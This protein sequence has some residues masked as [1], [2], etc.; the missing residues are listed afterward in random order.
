MGG[1]NQLAT[2]ALPMLFFICCGLPKISETNSGTW[3]D[4][5]P[6]VSYFPKR[7]ANKAS[8]RSPIHG[9]LDVGKG[10]SWGTNADDQN[11]ADLDGSQCL[12]LA[13]Q[14]QVASVCLLPPKIPDRAQ[15]KCPQ[16]N[17][18]AERKRRE[19]TEN[20]H[21]TTDS[22]THAPSRFRCTGPHHLLPSLPD[23]GCS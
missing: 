18:P 16:L 12:T 19:E 23:P 10:P 21:S 22:T 15:P 9:K 7:V 2:S 5:R 20:S 14:C 1:G 17:S 8:A 13:L 6:W 3:L 11:Q 4:V